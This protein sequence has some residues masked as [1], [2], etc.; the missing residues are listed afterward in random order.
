MWWG[1]VPQPRLH[2]N[3]TYYDIGNRICFVKDHERFAQ[4]DQVFDS[5]IGEHPVNRGKSCKSPARNATSRNL[6]DFKPVGRYD[7]CLWEQRTID[8]DDVLGDVHAT[9]V[10]NDSWMGSDNSLA[11][12]GVP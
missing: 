10:A 5:R 4:R 1:L 3:R 6:L 11:S 8:R 7:R 12:A 2:G 9:C